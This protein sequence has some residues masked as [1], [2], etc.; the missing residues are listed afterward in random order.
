MRHTPSDR[1]T[2]SSS[3]PKRGFAMRRRGCRSPRAVRA[4]SSQLSL[5]SRCTGNEARLPARATGRE[6]VIRV[7]HELAG[8]WSSRVAGAD[9]VGCARGGRGS[10]R[11]GSPR[12]KSCALTEMMSAKSEARSSPTVTVRGTGVSLRST[13]RSVSVSPTNRSRA[14]E[15][16]STGR[17]SVGALRVVGGVRSTRRPAGEQQ[18]DAPSTVSLLH[19]RRRVSSV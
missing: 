10:A 2:C 8:S 16:A 14:I 17:P 1:R 7:A 13:K 12:A 19:E 3:L 6:N 18:G 4:T 9:W 11:D 15:I 5:G